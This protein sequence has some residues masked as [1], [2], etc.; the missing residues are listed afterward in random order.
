MF[1]LYSTPLS[2]NGRKPLAVARQLGIAPVVH[3]VN[4]YV[5]EGQAPEYK[6]I[7]PLGKVPTLVDG[8]LVLWESNAI[9][10]YVAEAYGDYRLWSRDPRERADI[11]RWL[12]WESS[13]WQPAM[14]PVLADFVG[15]QLRPDA[16]PAPNGEPNWAHEGLQP[17]LVFLDHHLDGRRYLTGDALTLADFSVAAMTMFFRSNRFPF[18]DYPSLRDWCGR[19]EALDAW[20]ATAEGPWK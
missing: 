10:Q 3:A 8:E 17:L 13:H 1:T 20:Q 14:L 5:G 7:N 16:V 6:A 15:H 12:F 4:V 2:A 9:I 19:I 18:G 11:A